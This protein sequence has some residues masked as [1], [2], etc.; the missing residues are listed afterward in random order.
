MMVYLLLPLEYLCGK[1]IS[2]VQGTVNHN[3]VSTGF[4]NFYVPQQNK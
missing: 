4:S 3:K 1:F 2:L